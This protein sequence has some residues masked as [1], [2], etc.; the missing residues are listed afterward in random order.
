[1]LDEGHGKHGYDV[2]NQEYLQGNFPTKT[3]RRNQN[4]TDYTELTRHG[5][6]ISFECRR[7]NLISIEAIISTHC[8]HS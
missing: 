4:M 8:P 6:E 2:Q 3:E 1:M 7:P 5:K